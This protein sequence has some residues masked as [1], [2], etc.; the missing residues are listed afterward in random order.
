[1]NDPELYA[2]RTQRHI[3]LVL[4]YGLLFLIAGL[5][6]CAFLPFQINDKVLSIANPLITGVLSLTSGAVGFWIARHRPDT[7]T[8]LPNTPEKPK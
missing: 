2:A 6:A 3:T 5:I 8:P 4:L 7:S 1:M